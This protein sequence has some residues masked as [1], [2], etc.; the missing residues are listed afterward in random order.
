MERFK[1]CAGRVRVLAYGAG[2]RTL[3]A[4]GARDRRVTAWDV[5][6]RRVRFQRGHDGPV[7][8]LALSADGAVA[9]SADQ[10]GAIQ[11]WDAATGVVLNALRVEPPGAVSLA[12][13]PE[14]VGL[15]AA[16]FRAYWWADPLRPRGAGTDCDEILAAWLYYAVA[17]VVSPDGRWLAVAAGGRNPCYILRRLPDGHGFTRRCRAQASAFAFATGGSWMAVV[18][19]QAVELHE[20]VEL[21]EDKLGFTSELRATLRV[22]TGLV[23]G[24]AFQPSGGLLATVTTDGVTRLWTVPGGELAGAYDWGVGRVSAVAFAPDGLTCAAGGEGGQA[25]VWDVG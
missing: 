6:D 19:G 12:L 18:Q 3:F 1:V 9:A 23:R 22:G 25:V 10:T 7:A 8:A 15:A 11:L 24:V 17:V 5:A 13:A 2:G 14:A 21:P 16:G 4:A 20:I